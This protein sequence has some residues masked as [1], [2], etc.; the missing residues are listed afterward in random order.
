M[1]KTIKKWWRYLAAKLGLAL[2][3]K[4]DPKVQLEQAIKEARDQHRKLTEQAANVIANQKQL[5]LKLDRAIEEYEKANKSARQALL[6]SDQETRAGNADK[7]SSM[8]Q[9]AEA[10]ANKLIN[11]EAEIESLKKG[12]LE[13]TQASEKAKAAVT[14]NSAALQKKLAEKEKLLSQLDQAKMQEQMN[15]A[16]ATL[17]EAVGEEVP[18][19]DEVRNKI[20]KRLAKAQA[21]SDLTGASVDTKM[22]EV[23]QAQ[24]SAEAQA[25]L[26]ELR[27]ELGLEKPAEKADAKAAEAKSEGEA[28]EAKS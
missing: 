20:E 28:K 7:A 25:R 6:I 17:N 24:M 2:D 23:E 12:L 1:W 11:L 19:F 3:E 18:T 4:A 22:L 15:K 10:F 16:M 9:A 8:T 5:Q 13:A 21:T 27:S 14:Q 26:S